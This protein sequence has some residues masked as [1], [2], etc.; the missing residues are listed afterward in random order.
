MLYILF[1]L[2]LIAIPCHYQWSALLG[3][4]AVASDDNAPNGCGEEQEGGRPHH[5]TK[6]QA[7]GGGLR[8]GSVWVRMF[9]MLV[10]R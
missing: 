1:F 3:I 7:R 8:G 5:G 9:T 6:H 4:P 2:S 10:I